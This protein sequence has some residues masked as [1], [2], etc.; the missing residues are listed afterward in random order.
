M[1]PMDFWYAS[2]KDLKD[3]MDKYFS[4]NMVVMDKELVLKADLE[5]L[6]NMGNTIDKTLAIS[7]VGS[8]KKFF[9]K[10]KMEN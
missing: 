6:Y 4:N 9:G 7:L 10:D 1:N 3:C 2:N 8:Y 5:K